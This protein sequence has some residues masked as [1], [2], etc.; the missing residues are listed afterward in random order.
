MT[1]FT[2]RFV[3]NWLLHLCDEIVNNERKM[4]MLADYWTILIFV[5]LSTIYSMFGFILKINFLWFLPHICVK[6]LLLR[7]FFIYMIN[8][9][10]ST[11]CM[12]RHL[13]MESNTSEVCEVHINY[14][15]IFRIWNLY[16]VQN[17]SS[18]ACIH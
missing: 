3:L 5:C 13:L 12:T 7:F 8:N 11:K 18:L 15:H 9:S 14:I 4:W 17:I 1:V 16:P 2:H 10:H 6:I